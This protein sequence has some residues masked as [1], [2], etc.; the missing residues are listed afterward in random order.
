M[1]WLIL[2]LL[3]LN[4]SCVSGINEEKFCDI[5][6]QG[7][8]LAS[9]FYEQRKEPYCYFSNLA[10]VTY[11]YPR[12]SY[13]FLDN[14]PITN[15]V[16]R[17]SGPITTYSVSPALPSGLVLN[18]STGVISGTAISGSPETNYTF[19]AKGTNT[20]TANFVIKIRVGT[21]TAIR[22]YGQS[23][24]FSCG[25]INRSRSSCITS[26]PTANSLRLPIGM[27]EDST[28]NLYVSDSVN[29]RVLYFP[30][31]TT[32][33]SR[34]YGQNGDFTAAVPNNGGISASS[35]S[36]IR[37]V[38]VGL[39]DSLFIVEF[40]NHRAL[41]YTV[42][43]TVA[44][45]VFG[46]NGS[47]TT[48]VNSPVN[49]STLNGPQHLVQDSSGG[50]YIA[51][52]FNSRVLYYPNGST[53]ATRV[54]GQNGS[55]TTNTAGI[56]ANSLNLPI[57]LALDSTSGL[58]IVDFTNNRVLHYPKDSTVPDRVYGQ[59]GSYTCA[60]SANNNGSCVSVPTSPNAN[61][62]SSPRGIAV[63]AYDNVYISDGSNHRILFYQGTST[64][65]TRVYGQAGSFTTQVVNNG[66]ISASSLNQPLRL[67]IDPDGGLYAADQLNNRILY[68]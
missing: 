16:P 62:L 13:V 8:L 21:T 67:Y 48:N 45:G 40:D 17:I 20:I 61:S 1:K 19:S 51:D 41:S 47:F 59:F 58:F 52:G 18:S 42:N 65:P 60:N 32:T 9:I 22:V 24:D 35:L 28:G 64:T 4:Y 29:K 54:Y 55:F 7:F 11:S 38:I 66:G 68:Y 23:G 56:T 31:G 12:T 25:E 3:T 15:L 63:D 39:N 53:T 5:K 2:L 57:A 44:T 50:I 33:A 14:I 6:S 10:S 46:Q 37:N 36:D 30:K 34:V 49:A 43:S 26:T 27:H